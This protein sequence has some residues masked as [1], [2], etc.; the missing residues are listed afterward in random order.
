VVTIEFGSSLLGFHFFF[1]FLLFRAGHCC[2][3][4]F[5][6]SLRFFQS[7]RQTELSVCAREEWSLTINRV[8][9]RNRFMFV[10][11]PGDWL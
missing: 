11:S 4:V 3:D 2:E 1:S 8:G 10:Q 6:H 7:G 5:G 9:S